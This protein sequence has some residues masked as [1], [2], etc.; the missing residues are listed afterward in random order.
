MLALYRLNTD[1]SFK[2]M[3]SELHAINE[4]DTEQTVLEQ[5][6]NRN[7]NVKKKSAKSNHAKDEIDIHFQDFLKFR[8]HNDYND[9]KLSYMEAKAYFKNDTNEK[10]NDKKAKI[11]FGNLALNASSF[12]L[13]LKCE[14]NNEIPLISKRNNFKNNRSQSIELSPLDKHYYNWKTLKNQF[15]NAFKRSLGPST[16]S[17][18]TVYRVNDISQSIGNFKEGTENSF[19]QI[20]LIDKSKKK[21]T[22]NTLRRASKIKAI[23]DNQFNFGD[24]NSFQNISILD[25]NTLNLP[26]H[27]VD[28]NIATLDI[29]SKDLTLQN[30]SREHILPKIV[31]SKR[32]SFNNL[33]L[34][35]HFL[36]LKLEDLQSNENKEDEDFPNNAH[37]GESSFQ[38]ASDIPVFEQDE[39]KNSADD[40][41]GPNDD[42]F[43][44]EDR[45]NPL[46]MH[47]SNERTK[48]WIESHEYFFSNIEEFFNN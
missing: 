6:S 36:N 15:S 39:F 14:P 44:N 23:K 11:K 31:D 28:L 33:N 34:N 7:V 17:K 27:M 35:A 29:A 9:Y 26:D 1:V 21:L 25:V 10:T 12:N 18:P 46:K 20:K 2:N 13:P 19:S 4:N 32:T 30:K 24:S 48:E 22:I 41:R 47:L 37:D 38:L 3:D 16:D 8:K 45:K 40:I 5:I 42:E 43:L